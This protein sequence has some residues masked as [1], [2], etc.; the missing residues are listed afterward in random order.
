MRSEPL[1]A[2]CASSPGNGTGVAAVPPPGGR[3]DGGEVRGRPR[4]PQVE[5]AVRREL[6]RLTALLRRHFSTAGG[7]SLL[8]MLADTSDPDGA[9][10]ARQ[11]LEHIRALAEVLEVETARWS[12]P[13]ASATASATGGAIADFRRETMALLRGVEERLVGV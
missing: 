10:S 8:P 7:D 11:F 2:D 3:A 9:A 13:T 6:A 4:D 5:E 1:P 12:G